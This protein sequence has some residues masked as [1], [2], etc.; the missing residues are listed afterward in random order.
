MAGATRLK[1][2][3]KTWLLVLWEEE[4]ILFSV[5]DLLCCKILAILGN[6]DSN[7]L[8]CLEICVL[9]KGF[10]EEH[11]S[12]FSYFQITTPQWRSAQKEI[13]T[14]I[15]L[16]CFLH[17]LFKLDLCV[18]VCSF[19]FSFFCLF[20][21][22]GC[23][24]KS[25]QSHRMQ[26]LPPPPPPPVPTS[27]HTTACTHS[28]HT[29]TVQ[30]STTQQS[31]FPPIPVGNENFFYKFCFASLLNIFFFVL[32]W[33]PPFVMHASTSSQSLSP[34]PLA[35]LD[36]RSGGTLHVCACKSVAYKSHDCRP[37]PIAMLMCVRVCACVCVCVCVCVP[38]RARTS[39]FISQVS[40][41]SASG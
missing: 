11:P 1:R 5:Q 34:G 19:S 12:P 24:K 9:C 37:D 31:C 18:C 25:A 40:K 10:C 7:T 3:L 36:A 21:Y 8:F 38:A 6:L 30:T 14:V 28:T 32:V 35:W 2:I 39:V 22:A 13:F 17:L 23:Q 26:G 15:K 16:N 33:L 4:V 20:L 41:I 29:W 27:R